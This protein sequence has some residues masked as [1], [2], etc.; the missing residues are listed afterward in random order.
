MQFQST[1]ADIDGMAAGGNL[2]IVEESAQQPVWQEWGAQWRDLYILDRNGHLVTKINL[3]NFD[4]SPAANNGLNYAQLKA[5]FVHAEAIGVSSPQVNQQYVS[6]LSHDLLHRDANAT[7][8]A[9]WTGKLNAGIS[10][11]H[12]A[13]DIEQRKGFLQ[14]EVRSLY[15][16]YLHRQADPTA[17]VEF[18]QFLAE[19]GTL[20]Q[21]AADIVGSREYFRTR[22]GGT[23]DGFLDALYQDALGRAPNPTIRANWDSALL[24]GISRQQVA[25]AVFASTE[26]RRD[27]VE[28]LYGQLVHHPP[29]A[30]TL[31]HY[32]RLLRRGA[33]DQDVL[34]EIVASADYFQAR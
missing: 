30:A 20:E 21:V 16:H 9:I 26:Y 17:L 6:A 27:L 31:Q 12:V 24:R 33:R 10:R 18:T 4:P 3:T 32:I 14:D 25:A 2:P 34:A 29:T 23:N 8:L 28:S 7:E 5:L 13:L 11:V 19:G 1:T 22:G 15:V